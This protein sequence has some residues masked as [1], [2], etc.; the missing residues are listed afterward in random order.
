MLLLAFL[1][2]SYLDSARDQLYDTGVQVACDPR[3]TLYQDGDGDGYGDPNH[4]YIGCDTP[5]GFVA[6][7]TDC[8]DADATLTETC[9]TG[10]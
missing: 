8:N 3:V 10:A 2:C 7:G 1:G 6:D 5:S 4:V 9:D